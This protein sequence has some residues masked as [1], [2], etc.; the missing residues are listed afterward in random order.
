[1]QTTPRALRVLPPDPP[2]PPAHSGAHPHATATAVA[3]F[4]LVLATLSF[5]QARLR[6]RVLLLDR[7]VPG[8]GWVEVVALAA[9]GAFVARWLLDARQVASR[10]LELWTLFSVVFFSQLALGLLGF[11]RFLMTGAL[12]VPVPAMIVAGP[13]FRGGGLFMPILFGVTLLLVGPAWCSQLCYF[14]AWDGLA[15][16]AQPRTRKTPRWLPALRWVILG[17]V[18]LA[19][20]GLRVAGVPGPVAATLGITF[21]LGGVGVMLLVSRKKGVMVQCVG[22]CPIGAL[23]TTLGRVNPFRLEIGAGCTEC[24]LCSL[25]CRYRALEVEHLR[26]GRAGTSCTLCGDC[27]DSCHAQLIRFRFPGLSPTAA[28]ATF[29]AL[30]A[31]FHAV[32]LGVARI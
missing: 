16:T 17:A 26:R 12:H 4:L 30:V 29:V 1:M 20:I 19:A 6:L 5:L 15:A 27:L 11:S 31:A 3:A 7:F 8:A 14:G 18:V 25:V 24:R 10:R 28:R 2:A 32:F 9:Y 13:L 23:A 21:G 22:Y